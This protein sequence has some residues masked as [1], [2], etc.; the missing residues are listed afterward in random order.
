MI[1]LAA[2]REW[3]WVHLDQH[4]GVWFQHDQQRTST[5]R[6]AREREHPIIDLLLSLHQRL[7]ADE[8]LTPERSNAI[9]SALWHYAHRRFPFHPI[10]WTQVAVKARE[11]SPDSRPAHP[12]FETGILSQLNPLLMEWAMLP[13]RKVTTLYR[14]IKHSIV[15]WDYRRRL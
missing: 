2:H 4:V 8:R 5:V 3:R 1:N 14:E 12:I 11:I 6:V 13:A 15:G 7:L 10:H 9:A